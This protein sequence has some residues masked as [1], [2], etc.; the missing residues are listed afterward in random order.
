MGAD[1]APAAMA[2]PFS[3]LRRRGVLLSLML[4]LLVVDKGKHAHNDYLLMNRAN[5]EGF[6]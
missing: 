3:K 4:C 5:K 6:H 1:I 2:A